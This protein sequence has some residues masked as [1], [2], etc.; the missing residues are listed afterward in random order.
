[1]S[2]RLPRRFRIAALAAAAATLLSAGLAAAQLGD[3]SGP[4]ESVPQPP[5][6]CA[7][8]ISCQYA[9]RN[10]LG[11]NGGYRFQELILCGAN[12][13]TQY[14][15]S[16]MPE[17]KLLLATDPVRSGGIVTVGRST[18]DDVHPPIRVVLPDYGPNDAACCPSNW[19][20]TTYTWDPATSTLVAGTPN[21]VPTQGGPSIEDLRNEIRDA[22]FFDV[23]R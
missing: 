17:D 20:D 18:P 7:R 8:T 3:P 10:A 11:P 19:R 16:N 1:M 13:T 23:F 4:G 15:V 14:W 21:L 2:S 12:C 6:Q 22:G 9:E 5:A